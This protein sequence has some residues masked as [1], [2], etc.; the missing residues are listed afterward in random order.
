MCYFLPLERRNLKP[1]HIMRNEEIQFHA[2]FDELPFWSAPF[3]M[4]LLDSIP[5]QGVKNALDI[6]SGSGFPAIEAAMRF[7]NA[8]KVYALDSSACCCDK[9]KEKVEIMSVGNV[10]PVCADACNLPFNNNYF[11]LI[12]SNNG[13]NNIHPLE[14]AAAETYRTLKPKGSLVFTYNTN[15]TFLQFYQFFKESLAEKRLDSIIADVERHIEHK[16]PSIERMKEIFISAGFEFKS[17]RE[18]S[19]CFRFSSSEAAFGHYLIRT[20]F[21]P[22]WEAIAGEDIF[23][24]ILES[25]KIKLNQVL[26]N[27]DCIK[28]NVPMACVSF[29]K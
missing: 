28:F 3:G 12:I 9:I 1:K 24:D 19:F 4:L 5:M 27:S 15:D 8:A 21:L 17:C 25:V 16:R 7:G 20:A 18:E 14:T 10:F 2:E 6:G 29:M 11:D 13:F 22:V 26:K 23:S